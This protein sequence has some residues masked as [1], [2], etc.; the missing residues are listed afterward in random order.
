MDQIL[1]PYVQQDDAYIF[2]ITYSSSCIDLR[3]HLGDALPGHLSLT[4]E[5]S[6]CC[7]ALYDVVLWLSNARFVLVD[8]ACVD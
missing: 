1:A 3:L 8:L 5:S 4:L 6:S 7:C 2:E